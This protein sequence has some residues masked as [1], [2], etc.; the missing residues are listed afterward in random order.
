VYQRGGTETE[1]YVIL[2]GELKERRAK[3]SENFTKEEKAQLQSYCE[4]LLELY[5]IFRPCVTGNFCHLRTKGFLSDG[6]LIQFFRYHRKING[7]DKFEET[8][9]FNLDGLGGAYLM[10]LLNDSS[11]KHQMTPAL[12][13]NDKKVRIERI[14]GRGGSSIVY[15]G[16]I[17]VEYCTLSIGEHRKMRCEVL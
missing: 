5:Q 16:Q 6:K 9:V 4:D 12:V 15:E 1:Y 10:G 11:E 8:R 13:W 17:E 7:K 2:P 14:L 3:G